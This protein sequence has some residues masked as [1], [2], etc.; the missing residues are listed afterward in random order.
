[1]VAG[2]FKTENYDEVTLTPRS[3]DGGRDVIAVKHGVG[4]VRILGS[5]KA[6]AA[7]VEV[8]YDDVR[9]IAGVVLGDPKASK[10][11]ITTTSRFPPR[12]YEDA[13]VRMLSPTRL[14]LVDGSKLQAW[15]TKLLA[16]K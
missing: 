4:C 6:N 12:I 3:G 5:V 15:L 2:A 8:G 13:T 14:E 11:I 7:H 10:G 1:L 9:A 16:E